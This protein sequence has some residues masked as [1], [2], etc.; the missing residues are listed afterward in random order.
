MRIK[1]NIASLFILIL[2][3][4]GCRNNKQVKNTTT[5]NT[6]QQVTYIEQT[7]LTQTESSESNLISKDDNIYYDLDIDKLEELANQG[8]AKA[9]FSL[10][11]LYDWGEE[12]PQDYQKAFELYSKAA[13]QGYIYARYNLGI[14]YYDG[15]GI[16]KDYQKAFEL[17]SKAAKQ[18]FAYA[19]YNL[20]SMYYNGEYVN[21]DYSKAFKWYS[22]A[23]EQGDS[24]AQH[25]LGLMYYN[26]DGTKQNKQEGLE[27]INKS[28]EQGNT[29]AI[30][31]LNR[32]NKEMNTM[33]TTLKVTEQDIK[34][35][36]KNTIPES[37][38]TDKNFL[39]EAYLANEDKNTFDIDIQLEI[40]TSDIDTTKSVF[41]ELLDGVSNMALE[42][43]YNIEM[44]SFT[45]LNNGNSIGT[46][47]A[48]TGSDTYTILKDGKIEDFTR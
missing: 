12:V 40:G 44:Y 47:M 42:N 17:Y 39:C 22:K 2:I 31:F 46:F 21:Q 35:A 26:G 19:Q 20:G 11:R 32:L 14:M 7:T 36:I 43:G 1:R 24:D 23:A 25:N 16:S 15:N 34:N 41:Y 5:E 6:T 48:E 18:G 45:F 28:A 38:Q 8:D 37:Y 4:S 29:Y 30:D 13:E 10:G 33:E 27:W 3:I 9:Q